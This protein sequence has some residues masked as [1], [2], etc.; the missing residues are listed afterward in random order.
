MYVERAI[1]SVRR[2]CLNHVII[3]GKRHLKRI[4]T[5]YAE[6][7]NQSRTHYALDQDCP[8]SRAAQPVTAG[9]EIVSIPQVGGLHRRY[10][11]RAA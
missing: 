1:C 9:S 10:E 8:V 2:E 3:L 7:Y 4:L 11:R 5:A 6:Y